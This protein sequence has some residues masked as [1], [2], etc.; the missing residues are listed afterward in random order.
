MITVLSL[1]QFA[2]VA[3]GIAALKILNHSGAPVLPLFQQLDPCSPYLLLVPVLWTGFALVCQAINRG[4]FNL[5]LARIFGVIVAIAS[6]L[7]L[8]AVAFLH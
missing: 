2:F 5:N 7:F 1:T 4:P 3:L 8:V 6:F